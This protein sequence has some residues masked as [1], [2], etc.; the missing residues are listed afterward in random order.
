[1][2][3][4]APKPA[5]QAQNRIFKPHSISSAFLSWSSVDATLPRKYPGHH[6]HRLALAKSCRDDQGDR[7]AQHQRSPN[8]TFPGNYLAAETSSLEIAWE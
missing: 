8:A 1:M 4:R 6:A 5:G 3:N 2:T 7:R